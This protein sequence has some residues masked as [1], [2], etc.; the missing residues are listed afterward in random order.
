MY[1]VERAQVSITLRWCRLA[2]NKSSL[3]SSKAVLHNLQEA[4]KSSGERGDEQPS[5]SQSFLSE[6]HGEGQFSSQLQRKPQEEAGQ[7]PSLEFAE[8]ELQMFDYIS[9]VFDA[10]CGKCQACVECPILRV[11]FEVASAKLA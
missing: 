5:W 1:T 9:Q 2:R 4:P 10:S 11:R 6:G 3:A 8:P 7:G